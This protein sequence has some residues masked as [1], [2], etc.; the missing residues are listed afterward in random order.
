LNIVLV[1]SQRTASE[2]WKSLLVDQYIVDPSTFMEMEKKLTLERFQSEV[3][4]RNSLMRNMPVTHFYQTCV[5]F[6][7]YRIQGSTSVE[8]KSV[9]IIRKVDQR[10]QPVIEAMHRILAGEN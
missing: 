3:I 9:A 10:C 2:C 6:F 4:A 5:L 7:L 8:Q 1:K